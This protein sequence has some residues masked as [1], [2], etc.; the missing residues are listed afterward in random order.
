MGNRR[1]GSRKE[2]SEGIFIMALY[3]LIPGV[4]NIRCV[5]GD[6]FSTGFEFKKSGTAYNLTGFTFI[7]TIYSSVSPDTVVATFTTVQTDMATGKFSITLT[8]LQTA[9]LNIGKYNWKLT[10][11]NSIPQTAQRTYLSGTFEVLMP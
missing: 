1:D 10:G 7:G 3:N 11:D 4:L 6:Y 2:S 5:K 8:E 9:A